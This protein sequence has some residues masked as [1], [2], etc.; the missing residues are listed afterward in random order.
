M[1]ISQVSVNFNPIEDILIHNMGETK[2]G[3]YKYEIMNPLKPDERLT[4]TTITHKR[5]AR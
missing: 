2:S 3:I 1:L 4:E 5:S